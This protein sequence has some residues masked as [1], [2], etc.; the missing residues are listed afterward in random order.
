MATRHA[1]VLLGLLGFSTAAG[2]QDFHIDDVGA[3]ARTDAAQLKPLERLSKQQQMQYI[4]GQ[5]AQVESQLQANPA[6][7]DAVGPGPGHGLS[8][9]RL[10]EY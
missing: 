7:A 4:D 9:A 1:I 8:D 3:A 10:A 2:A 6:P 5:L